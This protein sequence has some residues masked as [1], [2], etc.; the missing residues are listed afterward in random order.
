M[1]GCS[2]S[3]FIYQQFVPTLW[4]SCWKIS[5][6]PANFFTEQLPKTDVDQAREALPTSTDGMHEEHDS[7]FG[8]Q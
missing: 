4:K 5:F 7:W 2:P 8:M 6:Y 3:A 1:M